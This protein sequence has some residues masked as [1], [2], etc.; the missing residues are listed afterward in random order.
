MDIVTDVGNPEDARRIAETAQDTFGGFDT[1]VNNAGVSIYGKLMDEPLEDMR[2]LFETNFWG[3]V[4]GSARSSTSGAP[5]RTVRSFCKA[6][7]A[8][9]NMPSKAS[10]MRYAWNLNRKVPPCP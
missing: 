3:V 1:W 5:C 6:C 7:T 8:R 4:Y 2:K 9:A 10:P